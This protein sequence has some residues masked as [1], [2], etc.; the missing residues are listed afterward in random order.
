MKPLHTYITEAGN[1]ISTSK[2]NKIRKGLMIDDRERLQDIQQLTSGR[3]NLPSIQDIEDLFQKSTYRDRV[4]DYFEYVTNW[5]G[6]V[7]IKPEDVVGYFS[8]G[9]SGEN[10]KIGVIAQVIH[11]LI[12]SGPIKEARDHI[13]FSFEDLIDTGCWTPND[14]FTG[15]DWKDVEKYLHRC[16][17]LVDED[18]YEIEDHMVRITNT[19]TGRSG[20]IWCEIDCKGTCKFNDIVKVVDALCDTLTNCIYSVKGTD[21]EFKDLVNRIM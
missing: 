14:D 16:F 3:N 2:L 19:G 8:L 17:T 15:R 4:D 10:M 18:V 20:D 6:S 5:L 7:G 21:K 9:R 1:P 13:T 11:A 12:A